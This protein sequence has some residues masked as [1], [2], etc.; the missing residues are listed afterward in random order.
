MILRF[1][2]RRGP[3]IKGAA[4][5]KLPICDCIL[6]LCT[7]KCVCEC[8]ANTARAVAQATGR[9]VR[10]R[11]ETVP[12]NRPPPSRRQSSV[13]PGG[14]PAVGPA[15]VPAAAA[16]VLPG[17]APPLGRAVGPP[18]C[19]LSPTSRAGALRGRRSAA[20]QAALSAGPAAA[21]GRA[22]GE[23]VPIGPPGAGLAEAPEARVAQNAESRRGASRDK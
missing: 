21:R 3:L 4:S 9:C 13:S 17:L 7:L 23:G 16:P 15:G 8:A 5:A 1:H 20:A 12:L 10:V 19:A 11:A 14:P 22:V 2:R 18:C 6:N